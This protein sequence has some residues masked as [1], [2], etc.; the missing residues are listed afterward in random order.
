M[1]K[2][3]YTDNEI[4]NDILSGARK[5]D[6][7]LKYLLVRSNYP[8]LVTQVVTNGGGGSKEAKEIF[9]DCLI[10]L[11]KKVRRYL[12]R[13]DISL[14]VFF[15]NEAKQLWSEELK[16]NKTKRDN[17][18]N[19]VNKDKN[20]RE[21]IYRAI[22][23]NSGIKEDA[24][25]CYQNGVILLDKKLR[26]GEYNG[27]AIN[28]FFYQ[29]CY[30]LWRN[31]LKKSKTFSIENKEYNQPI[32]NEDPADVME[33][34]EQAKLLNDLFQKLGESCQKI[35]QLKYLIIDQYS[36]EDIAQKMGFK[37]AQI[38]SNTLSKCRKALWQLLKEHKLYPLWM[39]RK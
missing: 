19:L 10:S 16:N 35:L 38:A 21:Q 5:R 8:D 9:S 36:M 15:E 31:E 6:S 28:G 22:M 33:R 25:D 7:A 34:N 20:L 27:G 17:L 18:L 37:N 13:E 30:N 29:I 12:I 4:I 32:T 24:E 14:S 2:K 11:D 1:N 39:K 26:E 3:K 23:K